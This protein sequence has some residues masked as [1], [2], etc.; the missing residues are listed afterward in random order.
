MEAWFGT[1]RNRTDI[2]L[3]PFIATGLVWDAP[4]LQKPCFNRAM[5]RTGPRGTM[6]E[7]RT[8]PCLATRVVS[9]VARH[10]SVL[11]PP[12]ILAFFLL[13]KRLLLPV[14]SLW[15]RRDEQ[16]GK[17]HWTCRL[18][19]QWKRDL[20]PRGRTAAAGAARRLEYLAQIRTCFSG[21]G[22]QTTRVLSAS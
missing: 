10:G 4:S 13:L 17:L 19:R 15:E 5:G 21:M 22:D 3:N 18:C 16:D 12:G 2:D 7:R 1:V 20:A 8:E 11:I 6:P 9:L 14:L